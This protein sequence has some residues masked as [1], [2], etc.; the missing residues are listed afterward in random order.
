MNLIRGLK[1]VS[2]LKD[3]PAAD[4]QYKKIEVWKALYT[5]YHPD[6]H[7]VT[8]QTINGQQSRQMATLNMAKV[9]AQEIATLVFNE[10]CIVNISDKTLQTNINDI[11][12]Q[13]C[14]SREFQRYL[15]YQFALGGLAIKVFVENGK[16]K[17]SFVT[18]ENF[19]P[20]SWNHDDITEGVF[21]NTFYK[22]G[23]KYTHLEWNLFNNGVYLIRN[24]LYESRH[25]EEIGVKIPLSTIFPNLQPETVIENVERPFFA[26]IKPN[27]ANNIDM[28]SPLGVSIYANA[29]DTLRA[30]DTAFDSFER[31]FKL[32]KKRILVPASC[33]RQVVDPTTGAMTRYF[34]ANDEVY[35]AFNFDDNMN[36]IEDISV[37]LRVEEH[38]AALNALLTHFSMQ[39]GFSA[40]AFTFDSAGLKTATEVISENSK[41]FR[42]KQA[43]E[44]TIE[45]GLQQLVKIIVAVAELYEVF[46]APAGEYDVTVTFDDS[47]AEDKAANANYYILLT[48]SGLVS[49]L[50]AIQKVLGLTEEQAR[51]MLQQ[52]SS[53]NA[54]VGAGD[55]D[56]FGAETGGAEGGQGGQIG[57]SGG[58]A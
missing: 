10:K 41:T 3:V 45:A 21:V 31:E 20:L 4:E 42:T 51:Q 15:E 44:T 56:L 24:E 39:I 8:Y 9:A 25:G 35:E 33:I 54:T 27:T 55:V 36:R 7:K 50:F 2:E 28:S 5:G 47:I 22:N 18:A 38:I 14:F 52:I 12:K 46:P 11:F 6:F 57:F 40:G 29:V 19:V 17:I 13:N 53:E 32:G 30:I 16:I 23:T 48:S 58:G 37:E 43:H 34:D 26:Y 49:K 1:Q